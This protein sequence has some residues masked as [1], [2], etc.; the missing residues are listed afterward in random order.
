MRALYDSVETREGY[1]DRFGSV[2][3]SVRVKLTAD[4]IRALHTTPQTLIAAPGPNKF[5]QVGTIAVYLDYSGGAFTGANDLEIRETNGAGTSL[6]S[7][8]GNITAAFLNGVADAVAENAANVY[9]AQTTRILNAPIV[10][11]VPTADPG[12]ALSTSTLTIIL[13]YKVVKVYNI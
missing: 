9:W 11:Y 4:E 13:F 12:G 2:I 1:I 3:N 7:A 5:I 10:A 6:F 8:G